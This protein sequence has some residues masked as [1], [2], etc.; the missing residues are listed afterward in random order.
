MATSVPRSYSRNVQP[1][2]IRNSAVGQNCV[3]QRC[4]PAECFAIGSTLDVI[5]EGLA[6]LDGAELEAEAQL[7]TQVD[8][9]RAELV[10]GDELVFPDGRFQRVQHPAHVAVADKALLLGL[11]L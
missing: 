9:G 6:L 2:E 11:E 3:I 8:V 4:G 7:R 1:G 5:L 10:A